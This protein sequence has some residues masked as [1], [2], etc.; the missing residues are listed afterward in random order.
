MNSVLKGG[1]VNRIFG[2][3]TAHGGVNQIGNTSVRLGRLDPE[4]LVKVGVKV[5]C[6]SPDIDFAHVVSVTS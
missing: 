5:D 4:G 3:R 6:G 2:K 1:K